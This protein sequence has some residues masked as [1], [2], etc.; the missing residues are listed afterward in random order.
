MDCSRPADGVWPKGLLFFNNCAV[1]DYKADLRNL[2]QRNLSFLVR[3][4]TCRAQ[5]KIEG[6]YCVQSDGSYLKASKFPG[7]NGDWRQMSG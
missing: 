6:L 7:Y 3:S 5:A 4:E 1:P 2:L